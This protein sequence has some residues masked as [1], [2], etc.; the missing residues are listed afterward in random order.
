MNE[1]NLDN[2]YSTRNRVELD[3]DDLEM[4]DSTCNFKLDTLSIDCA[5]VQYSNLD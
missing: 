3:Y 4:Y 1:F 5:S 2:L